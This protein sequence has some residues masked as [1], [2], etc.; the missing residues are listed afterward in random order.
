MLLTTFVTTAVRHSVSGVRNGLAICKRVAD[1]CG[2]VFPRYPVGLGW[3]VL[4]GVGRSVCYR[5]AVA[6]RQ[7]ELVGVSI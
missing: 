7:V 6:T 5:D 1:R 4:P 2:Y 3:S